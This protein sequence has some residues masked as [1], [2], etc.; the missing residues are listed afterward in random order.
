MMTV[1]ARAWAMVVVCRLVVEARALALDATPLGLGAPF[2][3]GDILQRE[4]AVPVWGWTAP[5]RRRQA[6]GFS[7]PSHRELRRG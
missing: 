6:D 4:M 3:D 1:A 7:R 5:G 2:V